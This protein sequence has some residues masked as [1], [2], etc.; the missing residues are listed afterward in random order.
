MNTIFGTK[1][2]QTQKFLED[3]SRIPVTIVMAK[4]N[5]VTA[6]KTTEVDG[7]QALQIGFGTRRKQIKSLVGHVKKANVE[8][9]PS[10]IREVRLTEN[11]SFQPGDMI[12]VEETFSPGDIIAVTGHS[13]GKGFAGGVKR[14][15][16]AGGPRTHGQSDRERAPGSIGQTTTPGRVY[17]G[18]K[19]AGRMGN[20]QVTVQN[21]MVMDVD[22]E[23][24]TL[25]I[26]GLVPGVLGSVVRIT[27]TGETKEKNFV[28]L[29]KIGEDPSESETPVIEEAP[30][31]EESQPVEEVQP[32]EEI[33]LEVEVAQEE[34]VSDASPSDA[35]EVKEEK[36]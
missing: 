35:G 18:K 28:A 34:P 6:V 10:L 4:D 7:Y 22:G 24:K 19:M 30:V 17:K 33:T 8:S 36:A 5:P 32:V 1:I 23:T 25:V 3:G 29:Y 11:S 31:V 16:F 9:V 13:K 14:H 12:K 27:K 26:K 20:E 21:L 2:T 15:G